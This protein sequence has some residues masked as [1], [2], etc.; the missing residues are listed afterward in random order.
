[1]KQKRKG[2]EDT[3]QK[4]GDVDGGEEVRWKEVRWKVVRW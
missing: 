4:Q 3:D 1:M 2:K